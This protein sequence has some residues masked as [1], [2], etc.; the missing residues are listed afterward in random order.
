M[1]RSPTAINAFL[2]LSGGGN[3]LDDLESGHGVD[4]E[5]FAALYAGLAIPEIGDHLAK[6]DQSRLTYKGKGGPDVLR[7]AVAGDVRDCE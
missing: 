1:D 3:A 5:T 4:P 6:D 2:V 7:V